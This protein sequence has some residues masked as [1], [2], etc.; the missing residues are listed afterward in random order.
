MGYELQAGDICTVQRQFKVDG[1]MAFNMG[2][3]V[4]ID[5][6]SVDAERPGFKYM[7]FSKPL[8]KYVRL[9]GVDLE[10]K[11]CPHCNS[12]LDPTDWKCVVCGWVLPGREQEA[13]EQDWEDFQ[14]HQREARREEDRH[15]RNGYL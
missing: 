5:A 3:E 15:W 14:E 6:I 13:M 12:E 8:N 7:A 10:L 1:Q 4:K 2:D 11:Y 9:R